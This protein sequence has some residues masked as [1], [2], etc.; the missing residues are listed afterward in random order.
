MA[1]AT[2]KAGAAAAA[3]RA[4]GEVGKGVWVMGAAGIVVGML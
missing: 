3:A 2:S 4:T 1:S